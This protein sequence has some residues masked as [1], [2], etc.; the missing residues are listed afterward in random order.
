M[1]FEKEFVKQK[2]RQLLVDLAAI[3]T[4]SGNERLAE[5]FFTRVSNDL[6]LE[7]KISD[8]NSYILGNSKEIL[9]VS[10]IDTVPGYIPV[11][12]DNGKIFG[13][14]VVDA[15]GPL[16]SMIFTAY[17]LK[18]NGINVTVAALADE[19]GESSGA[20][21]LLSKYNYKYIIVGEPTN[22]QIAIEYRGLLQLELLCKGNSYHS[23]SARE[24]LLLEIMKKVIRISRYYENFDSPTIQPTIISAGD[25]I[26]VT[27]SSVKICFDIR[28]PYGFN[29]GKLLEDLKIIFNECNF[30]TLQEIK[31]VKVP[32]SSPLVRATMRAILKIGERPRIVRKLGTS[33]MNILYKMTENIITIGPGDSSLE[34]TPNEVISLDELYK[35]FLIY[36]TLIEELCGLEKLKDC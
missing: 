32:L 36:K 12:E 33:D 5:N 27:P 28:Y 35:G 18:E 14:G 19:E 30:R 2:L 3:Y 21:E 25:S 13:R 6:N 16:V 24:N 26:N 34:H 29:I 17:V 15:K 11:R 8:T 23:S 1:Q 31:P 22:N 4:P 7:L 10:H 9:L 20:K